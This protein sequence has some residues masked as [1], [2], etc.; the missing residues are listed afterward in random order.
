[1]NLGRYLDRNARDRGSAPALTDRGST[2]TWQQLAERTRAL[3]AGLVH[4]VGCAAGDRVA[5]LTGN[6]TLVLEVYG[7]C[8]RAGMTYV[9]INFRSSVQ[10]VVRFVD[11]CRAR[12]LVIDRSHCH[13]IAPLAD[14]LGDG[15]ALLTE[16]EEPSGGAARRVDDIATRDGPSRL[17]EVDGSAT[18]S[19]LYTS[20]TE[21]VL[22][23]VPLS[24]EQTIAH[25]AFH[26]I[27]YALEPA[28]VCLLALPHTSA[29]SV[30]NMFAPWLMT[31]AQLVLDEGQ[32]FSAE[33]FFRLVH[34]HRVTHTHVVPTMAH[35]LLEFART[36]P[37][38]L[39]SMVTL[40]YGGAPMPPTRVAEMVE[41][42]GPIVIDVYG[43]TEV[44]SI[45]TV[46]RKTDHVRFHEAGDLT[47]LSSSGKASLGIDVTVRAND[48]TE[49]PIGE[50]GEIAFR[51]QYVTRGYWEAPELTAAAIRD[52]WLYSGDIGKLDEHGYLYVLDRKKDVIITGG[53]N[54]ASKEVEDVISQHE[55]VD[56]VAVVGSPH[57]EWGEVVRAFVIPREGA[58]LQ[59]EALIA[60]A[61]ERLAHYKC[62]AE[63]TLCEDLPRTSMG[64][65]LKSELRKACAAAPE[66]GVGL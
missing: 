51:G 35:R 39:S 10:E 50:V 14:L 60:F 23:A 41:R 20:G 62:P 36:H 4:R 63:I 17:S 52:G 21:G 61:R 19:L 45:A 59:P 53:L 3:A 34:R 42:F 9:P 11:H 38:D 13:L 27:E 66:Q 57:D 40:G 12:V 6:S 43:M 48:G 22:K 28:S 58:Q 2:L 46:L 18:C 30:N 15:V 33:R 49:V 25:A 1:M 7:A 26:V 65:V 8:V 55:L 16:D 44:A 24:Q 5:L 29:G 37:V 56:E 32:R 31:G 64:K 47:G 54:V